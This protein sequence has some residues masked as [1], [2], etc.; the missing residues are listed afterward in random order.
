MKSRF[1]ATSFYKDIQLEAVYVEPNVRS[2]P[3][4]ALYPF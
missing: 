1:A 3:A 2:K 4:E